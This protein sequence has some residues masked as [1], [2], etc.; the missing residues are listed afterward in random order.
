MNKYMFVKF[1]KIAQAIKCNGI[2][3]CFFRLKYTIKRKTGAIAGKSPVNKWGAI[4]LKDIVNSD[5]NEDLNCLLYKERIFFFDNISV[6]EL[7]PYLENTLSE[8]DEILQ[9]KLK[10]FFKD[11]YNF[12]TNEDWLKSPLSSSKIDASRHWSRTK[13]FDSQ[14]GDIKYV[15]EP[16]RFAWAYTLCRA[17]IAS[18]EDKYSEKFWQLF[19]NWLQINQ[20]N[21]GPNFAC[22][23]ECAIRLFAMCFAYFT[24]KK[25]QSTTSQRLMSLYKA[26]AIHADRIESNIEFAIS[27]R[28]NHSISEAAGIYTAGLI[29]PEMKNADRWLKR[30]RDILTSEGLKQIYKDGAYLQHS[31]NY[32]RLMLQDYIWVLR[33]AN[34]N[35]DKFNVKLTD[36]VKKAVE[37]IYQLQDDETGR[38][39]NYGPNDGALIIP[40]NNNDYLDYKPVI[41]AGWYLFNNE[42]LYDNG[43]WDED[44]LWLFGATALN[45]Q[46][47]KTKKKGT[48]FDNGGYYTIRQDNSWAMVRCHSYKD[49]MTQIDPLHFDFW[50]G[51]INILRDSGSYKYYIPENAKLENYFKS[52][53]AHNTITIDDSSPVNKITRFMFYPELIA[54][55]EK[56]E[57]Q[58]NKMFFKGKNYA[59]NRNPWKVLHFRTIKCD[60]DK[61]QIIDEFK[62]GSE[63]S[64][65]LRWHMPVEAEI[66]KRNDYGIKFSL[67]NQWILE[68]NGSGKC[69]VDILEGCDIGGWESLYYGKLSKIKTLSVNMQI[70]CSN[71]FFKTSI[72]EESI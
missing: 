20:P 19:E 48:A 68:I 23:Q 11:Y 65:T 33:L 59:Y 9:G 45:C 2:G 14:V 52:I 3:F 22:G 31:M 60:T 8:A 15:W 50:A 42:K 44:L 4:E 40:L 66:I 62:A 27:T 35:K 26:I 36:R 5:V 24:L 61:W 49:R 58:G 17:Y 57:L 71:S 6:Q 41:Q 51:G 1:K 37:F 21:C 16:S 53:K 38:V 69:G 29:F 39:P 7:K 64:A 46:R 72:F 28:T 32:H 67:P 56:F 54:K 10:Y 43:H 30:G 25:A 63:H 70:N 34:L 12:N 55:A 47:S 13:T 18:G